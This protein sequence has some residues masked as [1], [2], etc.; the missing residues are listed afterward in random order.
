MEDT[1]KLNYKTNGVEFDFPEFSDTPNFRYVIASSPRC[2]SNMLQRV[3]WRSGEAG[4]PEEYLTEKYIED[5][6]KRWPQIFRKKSEVDLIEYMKHLFRYRT[7]PNGAFGI[8]LHGSHLD[9]VRKKDFNLI[10]VLQH[11]KFIWIKRRNKIYQAVSY[12]LANQTNI[13]IIDGKW[14]DFEKPKVDNPQYIENQITE[15]LKDIIH[16]EQVWGDF[17]SENRIQ[18]HVIYYEDLVVDYIRITQECFSNL[19]IKFPVERIPSPGI[20]KQSSKINDIWAERY[21]ED[22]IRSKVNQ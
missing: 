4:A 18:P 22:L 13:W 15:C 6:S 10:A 5:F 14:L 19:G 3:L 8:K 17:F 2:G 11:P 12:A 20:K 16:N 1:I 9:N 7:S 21:Y